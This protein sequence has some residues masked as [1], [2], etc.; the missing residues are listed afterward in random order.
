MWGVIIAEH[1]RGPHGTLERTETFE[2]QGN[3][4]MK[5]KFTKRLLSWVMAAAMVISM[6]PISA[7]ASGTTT[8]SVAKIGETTYTS[9]DEAVE[10]AEE[11]STI[12]L[13]QDCELTKGFNKTLTF[14]GDG[15]ISINKQLT[16]N[17]EGWMCFGLYDPS[18]VLTF[19]G[20]GV[21]VEWTSDGSA[22]WLMLSLSGTLNV[23]NG[24]K[25]TYNFDS[26]TTGTR[27]AIYMNA[28]STINVTNGS[29]LQILGVGTGDNAGQ[30]IQLDTAGT[31]TVNVTG[32]STF[33]IDGTN[34]GYVNSPTIYVNGST[35]A[36]Q[37]C[38]S[39]GSNGGTF[40]AIDSQ[41][42]YENNNGHGLSAGNVTIQ[43]STL[44]CN[45]NAYYGLTYS[46]NMTMDSTSVINANGNGYGY[47][48]GGL[49]AYGT[50]T[51]D[52]GAKINILNNKRNGME[53]YGTFN[54]A[55]GATVTVTGN[56]EPS[57]NGG[58]IY[59]GGTL[60]LPTDTTIM[61]NY[62][63]QTGGG[64][65]NAGT[66]TIPNGVELYNNHADNAGDDIFNRDGATINNLPDIDI[67]TGWA[68]D[69]AEDE[70]DC[71]GESHM[72][73][74]W[75]DDAEGA[76]WEAHAVD[77][78]EN[79]IEKYEGTTI[80][81]LK[82][83]KAAHGTD[84]KDKT[85][86][87]GLDKT[88]V[89][90]D[91]EVKQDDVA[92]GDTVNFKLTSNVPDDL[93][94]YIIP[95]VDEPEVVE[96]VATNALVPVEDRGHYNLTFHDRM[97]EELDSNDDFTVFLDKDEDGVLD[98]GEDL[99]SPDDYT[100]SYDVSHEGEEEIC[101]FEITMDLVDLYE[102][103]AITDEDIE[104][105]TPIVVTYTA[106]LDKDA[107]AGEYK[108]TAWVTYE[109]GSS[110]EVIVTVETYGLNIFKY[111]QATASTDEDGTWKATG[112]EGAVFTLTKE[113]DD[114]FE[115]MTL[116]SDANGY[117]TVNGLDAGTY[118]LTETTPPEGYVGSSES[119]TIVIGGENGQENTLNIVD[120]RFANSLIP[121]T[122]GMGTTMFSIVG[123]ALI[124]TAGVIF[125][126]SR[127]KR[128]RNAA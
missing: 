103:G 77:P 88:I 102:K 10:K 41:I 73:D 60:V 92:A 123:G 30:G 115:A 107:T 11:G 90:G 14:T 27:N 101:D 76:R 8:G 93:L 32:G 59:N 15:K 17:G 70:L 16:S 87:P 91:S 22:P 55:E 4:R 34:R 67:N 121:H 31:A 106:T 79:H 65:C 45:N 19:D 39:N 75:Y 53:N 61:N 1:R 21:E 118:I 9:L 112:L 66:V 7:M 13:L 98:E 125:V 47:T 99:I 86:Y 46:G 54:V 109:S 64:I 56:N 84:Y 127:K 71:N 33:T 26:R 80:N 74:G 50:S 78:S 24:A 126:I 49:R 114:T 120:I 6:L 104:N 28:G 124:A 100:I 117:I 128:A 36:V 105:A 68:L 48:G 58:G 69:G 110:S 122:G 119:L 51:V 35:F 38:T 111:D 113:D 89:V 108:N 96:P 29:T 37:N 5:K 116:E 81:G 12:E 23:T 72:I 20:P 62:A 42:T 25:L 57:T 82:A 40:T 52:A 94:N 63:E 83:L 44:N 85:S 18:R 95:D 3:E 43:N 2:R 97:D